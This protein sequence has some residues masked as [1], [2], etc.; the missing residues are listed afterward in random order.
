MGDFV[1][2]APIGSIDGNGATLT[3]KNKKKIQDKVTVN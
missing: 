1:T 3:C 2:A